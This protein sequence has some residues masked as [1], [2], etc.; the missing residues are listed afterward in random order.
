MKCWECI[1]EAGPGGSIALPSLGETQ[2]E[3]PSRPS[4]RFEEGKKAASVHWK[5]SCEKRLAET[6]RNLTTAAAGGH[7]WTRCEALCGP[8]CMVTSKSPELA[9]TF[10][11]PSPWVNSS[12]RI[13]SAK[14]HFHVPRSCRGAAGPGCDL[15]RRLRRG[16]AARHGAGEGGAD[17]GQIRLSD[18][19]SASP[20]AVTRPT[21]HPTIHTW[22]VLP[23]C[24]C[25]P[26]EPAPSSLFKPTSPSPTRAAYPRCVSCKFRGTSRTTWVRGQ[27]SICPHCSYLVRSF[28]MK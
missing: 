7:V 21:A 13:L 16:R 18:R 14:L 28:L 12:P 25:P 19:A 5:S 10:G 8:T 20:H 1:P 2:A 9:D 24:S 4:G 23:R 22:H 17:E 26:G 3:A 11:K 15:R 27:R 6:R